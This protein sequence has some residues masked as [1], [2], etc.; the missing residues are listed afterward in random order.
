MIW[1]S[2]QIPLFLSTAF[3]KCTKGGNS[4]PNASLLHRKISSKK[5][6]QYWIHHLLFTILQTVNPKY[7]AAALFHLQ[8]IPCRMTPGAN[9]STFLKIL[10]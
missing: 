7:T 3:L 1:H 9:V 10:N 4:E 5:R 2:W 6:H 8:I